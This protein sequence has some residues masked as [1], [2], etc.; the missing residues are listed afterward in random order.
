[1]NRLPSPDIDWFPDA[2]ADRTNA[3]GEVNTSI[4]DD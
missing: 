2:A 4:F 3:F 1:M